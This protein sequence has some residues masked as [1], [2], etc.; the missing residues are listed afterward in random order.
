[1]TSLT[2]DAREN[3]VIGTS[4]HLAIGCTCSPCHPERARVDASASRRIYAFFKDLLLV[5]LA[6][7]REIFDEAAYDRFL[8]R[9]KSE[10]S[11]ESYCA[12]LRE[13]ELDIAR[14][15]RCC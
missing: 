5:V 13:Q 7:L 15:P 8:A 6:A 14:K 1:M 3:R 4:G 12:F 2:T 10:R 9:K 11:V